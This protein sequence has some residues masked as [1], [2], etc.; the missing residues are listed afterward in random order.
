MFSI[1]KSYNFTTLDPAMLGASYNNMKVK[2]IVTF[3]EA[4][5]YADVATLHN[6]VKHVIP[7]L[8]SLPNDMTYILFVDPAGI[9]KILAEAYIDPNSVVA[10]TTVNLQVNIFGVDS[11]ME[12]IIRT[13]LKEIGVTTFEVKQVAV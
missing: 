5:K 3:D 6:N 11:A 10:V 8:P 13:R 9:T 7:G 1:N 2:G 4:V 12:S